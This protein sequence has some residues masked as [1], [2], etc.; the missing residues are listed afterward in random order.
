[1]KPRA[2]AICKG[3]RW[4]GE[5]NGRGG[6]RLALASGEQEGRMIVNTS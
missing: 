1:M 4:D 6:E 3:I 2:R 5:V